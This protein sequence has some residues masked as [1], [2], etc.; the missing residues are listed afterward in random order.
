LMCEA[1]KR[2][3]LEMAAFQHETQARRV[4]GTVTFSLDPPLLK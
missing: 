4:P 2:F 1:V 3:R